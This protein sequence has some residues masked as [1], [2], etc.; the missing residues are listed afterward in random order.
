MPLSIQTN[1][2]SL[3]A[4]NNIRVNSAFQANTINQLSS[5]FRINSSADDAAGLGV[6]N[7]Y[8]GDTAELTQG[9]LN[10]QNGVAALQIVDGGLNNISNILDRLRTLATQS[11]SATFTGDRGTLNTEYQGLLTEINRQASNV[12]LNTGGT[13]NTNLVTYVGGGSTTANAQVSVDLSGT[14]SAVD[15][16]ALGI[17]TSS[18][19]GGGT[20]IGGNTVRLD[21]TA[22]SFLTGTTQSFTFSV[23]TGTGNQDISVAVAGGGSGLSGTQVISSLNNSL[24]AYGISASVGSNGTLQFGG[25][26]AFT[27]STTAG[28]TG[29][30]SSTG[31]ATNSSVNSINST[32]TAF[33][34]GGGT[35]A[36]ETFVVQNGAGAYTVSLTATNAATLATAIGTINTALNGSGVYAVKDSA[37][38]GIS[39]Q[40]GSSFSVNET[41]FTAGAGGGTGAAFGSVGAKTVTAANANSSNAGNAI[42]ALEAL[43]TAV[44]NLGLVQGKVGAGQNKLNYAVN[45]A[46][47]QITNYSAAQ[48][49]IRDADVAAQAANLTKAQVLQQASLAALAQ[50]NSAPQAVLSLLRG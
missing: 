35:A 42:A 8:R 16:S 3:T 15:S 48:A 44:G 7:K 31:S 50:A 47:S 46:Q 13:Y 39:I 5:G 27:V 30:I 20:A 40:S 43:Q 29:P 9:V 41:A 4:Q 28:G 22:V 11:A 10:A 17:S 12:K 26:T 19:A 49:G 45:L 37:G 33:A 34:T 36:A 23:N 32:F 38:T 6:A 14:N 25:N 21:N 2:A 18:V 1:I 24:S